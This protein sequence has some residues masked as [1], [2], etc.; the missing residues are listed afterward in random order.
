MDKSALKKLFEVRGRTTA[1][2]TECGITSQAVSQWDR[3][4]AEHVLIVERIT[5]APR[6]DLR[7]DIYPKEQTDG[8]T[9]QTDE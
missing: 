1:V 5:G 6:Y 8:P 3:V 7:P 2:A 4:P 9:P